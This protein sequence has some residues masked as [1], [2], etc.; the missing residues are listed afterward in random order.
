[1]T[2][3]RAAAGEGGRHFTSTPSRR[4][5]RPHSD[6]DNQR[7]REEDGGSGRTSPTVVRQSPRF[8]HDRPGP[9][10]IA[11]SS[12]PRRVA[13]LDALFD[14]DNDNDKDND[15][16]NNATNEEVR[17]RD[18]S[19]RDGVVGAKRHPPTARS[20]T[21][22]SSSSDGPGRKENGRSTKRLPK[23][24]NSRTTDEER[25][26]SE[27]GFD[28]DD[29]EYHPEGSAD[30]D[31]DDD[32][33]SDP[34]DYD[35]DVIY[36][37]K[38]RQS[39][40]NFIGAMGEDSESD[41][42]AIFSSDQDA[43]DER[44]G[45]REERRRLRV[46]ARYN[47]RGPLRRDERLEKLRRE[48][49]RR[50][51][52]RPPRQSPRH[53][54]GGHAHG[55]GPQ[56]QGILDKV[57][58]SFVAEYLQ[59]QRDANLSDGH[60]KHGKYKYDDK[61]DKQQQG[62]EESGGMPSSMVVE[63]E[64]PLQLQPPPTGAKNVFSRIAGVGD[65]VRR[66][67]EM[68]VFPLLYPDLFARLNISP[69]RGVLF[70]GPP[71]TG[72]T[73]LARLL[74]ESCSTH[75]RKVSFFMRNGSDCLSK[76]IGEAERNLKLLF[77]KAKEC[78]P[79]IIFFDELD[80]LAPERSGKAEQ[81]HISLV[82]TLLALMDGL[83][84]RGNV[85]VIGA[86]NRI[87]ALDPALR[88]PGRFD[89]EFYFALPDEQV[90]RDI[91]LVHTDCWPAE[92]RP[93]TALLDTLAKATFGYAGADLRALCTEAA[94]RSIRRCC[95]RAYD[96]DRDA[97]LRDLRDADVCIL[98]TDF[99]AA[100]QDLTPSTRRQVNGREP[101][102]L[103][104]ALQA[105]Y[106]DFCQR[107]ARLVR[108]I[109][110]PPMA[111]GLLGANV[112]FLAQNLVRVVVDPAI[113][114][115]R[116]ARRIVSAS[117]ASLSGIQV[118]HAK[119]DGGDVVTQ[120]ALLERE[121]RDAQS[122]VASKPTV[123]VVQTAQW[124][125]L[126]SLARSLLLLSE[127]FV[128]LVLCPL[129]SHA[130]VEDDDGDYADDHNADGDYADDHGADD[131][132]EMM[133]MPKDNNSVVT[134]T[135]GDFGDARRDAFLAAFCTGDTLRMYVRR[136]SAEDIERQARHLNLPITF[137]LFDYGSL[138]EH[139]AASMAPS[140]QWHALLMPTSLDDW[141][142]IGQLALQFVHRHLS[143]TSPSLS[144]FSYSPRTS[145]PALERALSHLVRALQLAPP[146]AAPRSDDE[147][148]AVHDHDHEQG[149]YGYPSLENL[150]RALSSPSS[151]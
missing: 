39:R 83:D 6:G 147:A 124:P 130:I 119:E 42:E 91:L 2:V 18:A 59:A 109:F 104:P 101:G 56:G 87:Q 137:P 143:S 113:L 132:D 120:Q 37:Q 146:F 27:E 38:R 76:W 98:P 28:R 43:G 121:I 44:Q 92:T 86:T 131:H 9:T 79:A 80:G 19:G 77:Q 14:D 93:S 16:D 15:S 61:H 33:D 69:P 142:L 122:L 41:F 85:V 116:Y 145:V 40:N 140:E 50:Y 73:L 36:S 141:Q 127:P 66:L 90:R 51:N 22:T 135:L 94:F 63:E 78:Q 25:S 139:V 21:A 34:E 48:R 35:G 96:D 84:D 12:R 65:Y 62:M 112:Y 144:S 70:H 54:Q 110:G 117:L 57:P 67:K 49:L 24:S 114:P 5:S 60:G 103:S 74:A 30:H 11:S 3:G 105:L 133:D 106:G 55:N 1:M 107:L 150:I 64:S 99:A 72:K 45:R 97:A 129:A 20:S 136:P 47:L 128:L 75:D 148:D 71:G 52:L 46:Q 82:S 88:R 58:W 138:E 7:G 29:E 10:S 31:Q 125:L 81:S 68:I 118:L 115:W 4:I 102:T 8:S 13:T 26:A 111:T 17:D 100:L 134:L 108:Q 95:P 149:L 123:L 89:R 32:D 23:L 151:S 126:R 53:R